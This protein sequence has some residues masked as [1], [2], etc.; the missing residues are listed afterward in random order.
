MTKDASDGNLNGAFAQAFHSYAMKYSFIA[1]PNYGNSLN[2]YRL[3]VGYRLFEKYGWIVG[4]RDCSTIL[5]L[6]QW[7]PD[8]CE[9]L[10]DL[11]QRASPECSGMN[12]PGWKSKYRPGQR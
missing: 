5:P 3:E 10:I 4:E 9:A 12:P 8:D 11:Y 7:E 1:I 6:D 2:Q